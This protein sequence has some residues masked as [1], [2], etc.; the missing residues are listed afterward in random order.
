LTAIQRNSQ[1]VG[2]SEETGTAALDDDDSLNL[3]SNS[4]LEAV[5]EQAVVKPG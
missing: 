4:E 1:L 3:V 5:G 2:N